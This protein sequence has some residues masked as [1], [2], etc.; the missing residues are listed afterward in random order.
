MRLLVC[1]GFILGGG[2]LLRGARIQGL[3]GICL[4]LGLAGVLGVLLLCELVVRVSGSEFYRFPCFHF[5]SA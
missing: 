5:R 4:S 1:G 3:L 2:C